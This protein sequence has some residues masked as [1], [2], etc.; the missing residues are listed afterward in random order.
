M[1]AKTAYRTTV[2]ESTGELPFQL[3]YGCN[4]KLR[5]NRIRPVMSSGLYTG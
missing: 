1:L 2:Q 3:L 5:T 4:P